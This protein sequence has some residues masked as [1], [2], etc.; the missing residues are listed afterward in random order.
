MK[1]RPEEQLLREQASL[2]HK[3]NSIRRSPG[4]NLLVACLIV[5]WVAAVIHSLDQTGPTPGK[6]LYLLLEIKINMKVTQGKKSF[7]RQVFTAMHFLLCDPSQTK[8]ASG[9]GWQGPLGLFLLLR[10][11]LRFLA[12]GVSIGGPTRF[13]FNQCHCSNS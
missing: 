2:E 9:C 6:Q 13:G 8:P 3:T 4:A 10:L 5:K 7:K 12:C 11:G 1:N